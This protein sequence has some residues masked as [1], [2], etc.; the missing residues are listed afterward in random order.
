MEPECD[1][2]SNAQK[3]CFLRLLSHSP[4]FLAAQ[5]KNVHLTWS[6]TKVGIPAFDVPEMSE[7]LVIISLAIIAIIAVLFIE[8]RFLFYP[9]S[10]N[11]NPLT[12]AKQYELTGNT[13]FISDLHL[14]ATAPFQFTQELRSCV[15]EEE[16]ANLVI[17]GD[18]FDSPE[19]AERILGTESNGQLEYLGLRNIQLNTYWIL[20][21]PPHDPRNPNTHLH[22]LG[23]CAIFTCKG[24]S[25][26]AYHGHDMSMKGGIA[27]AIDRFVSPLLMEKLW[28]RFA[29]V[30]VDS[31]VVFGHS[32][33]PGL[34]T[35]A[36]V[37]N[38]GAWATYRLVHP[39]GTGVVLKASSQTLCLITITSYGSS[40]RDL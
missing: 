27:H 23:N 7:F 33:I 31:W 8:F 39:T 5:S 28:K 36:R 2:Y 19:D 30:K 20:G 24:L 34:D 11:L 4:M 18:L 1:L 10:S 25:I 37:A 16:I 21:S 15:N 22:V 12:S 35:K 13:L 26:I 32:H 14:R 3:S 9:F 40:T 38:C 6:Y 29:H 17:D